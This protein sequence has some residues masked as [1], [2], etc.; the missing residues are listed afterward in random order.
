MTARPTAPPSPSTPAGQ[1]LAAMPCYTSFCGRV[2]LYL[3]DCLTIAPT[4]Q[5]VDAVVSDPPYGMGYKRSGNSRN[6]ISSTGKV[7]TE[8][9]EGDDVPFDPSPWVKWPAVMTGGQWF[10]DRLPAG[11]VIH[12]WDKRGPYEAIDQADVDQIWCSLRKP[13]R[14]LECVWRGL[15]RKTEV[16]EPIVHPTQKPVMVMA[17]MMERLEVAAG[18]LVLDPYMGS[19]TTGLAAIRTGRR[20]VGIE[21]D[22]THYATALKRITDELAQGDLFHGCNNKFADA[23]RS[24][25]RSVQKI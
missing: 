11:G 14:K 5:G 16:S 3:G 17:W 22:P 21:K 4:L 25:Q 19:G 18:A 24:A 8:T 9:I 13:A 1:S 23:E 20:F 6:S 7:W 12:T 2:T 15:C 10:Y